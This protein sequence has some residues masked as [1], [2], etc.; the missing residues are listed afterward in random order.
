VPRALLAIDP[1]KGQTVQ[2][3]TIPTNVKE[4][5]NFLGM[6]R[7]YRKFVH[8]FGIISK[9]LAN[10]LRKGTI[11]VWTDDAQQS[12]DTLKLS[13]AQAAVLG[14]PNFQKPFVIETDASGDR[15]GAVHQ[16]DSV[17]GGHS[18][19]LVTYRRL[20]TTFVW[21]G[22]KK[23][24]K[25]FVQSS[26]VCQHGILSA[27]ILSLVYLYHTSITAFCWSWISFQ[28]MHT[29]CAWLI[30]LQLSQWPNCICLRYIAFMVYQQH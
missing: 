29:F 21:P 20:K 3:W 6:A 15:I 25:E 7:Y 16:Q 26:L 27:W 30:P 18:G 1:R 2:E 5:H 12:F 10:L 23:Q 14:I 19:F 13:L 24:V 11:F 22:M 9:P 4:L 17:V 28:N 8:H